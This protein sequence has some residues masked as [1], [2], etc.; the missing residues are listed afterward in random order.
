MNEISKNIKMVICDSIEYIIDDKNTLIR[1]VSIGDRINAKIPHTFSTGEKIESIGLQVCVG[2]FNKII[3]SDEI[4]KITDGAFQ[5]ADVFRVVWSK[6]CKVIPEY[7]FR[8][9]ALKRIE[10]I[11]DVEEIQKGAFSDCLEGEFKWPSKC[12]KISACFYESNLT[13][14]SNIDDIEE[15]TEL[16]F[17]GSTLKTICWPSKCFEIPNRCFMGSKL[18]KIENIDHV[19]K[20]GRRAFESTPL[21]TIEWPSACDTVPVMCFRCSD[22]KTVYNTQA[23]KQSELIARDDEHPFFGC[24]KVE[25]IPDKQNASNVEVECT[26]PAW[27]SIMA[28]KE[29]IDL[30]ALLTETLESMVGKPKESTYW[31]PD[32]MEKIHKYLEETETHLCIPGKAVEKLYKQFCEDRYCASWL[33][34]TD[35]LIK[36]FVEYLF[37]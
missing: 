34:V 13:S 2:K 25:M 35:G 11:D 33:E 26:L 32:Q 5:R 1:M 36:E 31:Y 27:L 3:I 16:A 12:K 6:G 4:T 10:N 7:C 19:K 28:D 17:A 37:K 24:G 23:I 14:I 18:A 29:G 9:S 8:E 22:I 20:I 30:S 21:E 15:V